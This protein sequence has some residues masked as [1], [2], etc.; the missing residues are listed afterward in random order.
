MGSAG[1]VQNYV[2]GI[3]VVSLQGDKYAAFVSRQTLL[4]EATMAGSF[5]GGQREDPGP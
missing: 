4:P 3:V 2:A 1:D 5:L